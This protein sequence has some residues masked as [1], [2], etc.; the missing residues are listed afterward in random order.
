VRLP[1]LEALYWEVIRAYFGGIGPPHMLR[2]DDVY[3]GYFIPK[4]AIILTN[5]WQFS[6]DP[7]IY[8]N[9]EV[10]SPERFLASEGGVKEA[11][12]RDYIFGFGRRI[13][14]AKHFADASLWL[15]CASV[16]ATFDIRPPV[17]DGKPVLPSVK[18]TDGAIPHPEPFEC[19]IKP[20][21]KVAEA[22]I[23]S[24]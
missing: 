19:V 4:G 1:Y 24:V 14:P 8:A 2:E 21:S 23:L 15:A 3:N 11:D 16:L 12:P 13:C 10:F 22:L 6:K 20:R 5:L 9:P 18:Y 7:K 17:K